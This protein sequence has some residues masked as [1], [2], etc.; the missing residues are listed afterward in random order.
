DPLAV[1]VTDPLLLERVLRWETRVIQV[2]ELP[3]GASIGY[4]RTYRTQDPARI[5][6]IPVG[7]A[8]GYPHALSNRGYVLIRGKRCPVRGSVCMDQTMV[9]VTHLP[10]VRQGDPVTLIGVDGPDQITAEELA[11][12]AGT[13]PYVILT[14]IGS[15]VERVYIGEP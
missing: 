6:V 8:D 5:A 14:G 13:I 15:R 3:G 12:W 9:E 7:Y 1:T 4:G 11:R 10:E 2:R